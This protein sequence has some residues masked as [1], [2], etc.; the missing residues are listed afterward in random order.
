VGCE[1]GRVVAGTVWLGA[2][3]LGWLPLYPLVSAVSGFGA[4]SWPSRG[5][6]LPLGGCAS[7]G[8]PGYAFHSRVR[9]YHTSYV[10]E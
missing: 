6:W 10:A 1:W 8:G 9:H 2:G 3:A 4:G 5:V 7:R